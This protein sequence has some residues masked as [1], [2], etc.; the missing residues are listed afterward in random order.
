MLAPL[1]GDRYLFGSVAGRFF[2]VTHQSAS[3]IDTPT[4]TPHVAAFTD[5]TDTV[6][7]LGAGGE[8]ATYRLDS[9]FA[10]A[11][12]TA[13]RS[14]DGDTGDL[15]GTTAAPLELFAVSRNGVI[16]H[17]AA[18]AW[19][20]LVDDPVGGHDSPGAALLGPSRAV[21]IGPRH[22]TAI[23]YDHGSLTEEPVAGGA[24]APGLNAI[25]HVDALG[26]VAGTLAGRHW[27][28][29]DD[30]GGWRVIDDPPSSTVV[31]ALAPFGRGFLSGGINGFVTE[32]NPALGYCEPLQLGS[33]GITRM[34]ATEGGGVVMTAIHQVEMGDAPDVVTFIDPD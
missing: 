25:T 26:T 24:G 11:G 5:A 7:L 19:E 8:L 1:G 22:S 13:S 29:D 16:D 33:N 2:L 21:M 34:I 20:V 30:G 3:P 15:A 28:R 4:T 32:Y 6:W 27:I 18:G 9:G 23:V 31:R 10:P 14:G 12:T 17:L